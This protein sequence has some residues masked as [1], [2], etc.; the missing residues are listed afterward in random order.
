MNVVLIFTF[1]SNTSDRMRRQTLAA[2]QRIDPGDNLLT[3]RLVLCS[4]ATDRHGTTSAYVKNKKITLLTTISKA[5]IQIT[6]E[7]FLF[8][9]LLDI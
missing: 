3:V 5:K 9:F 1:H 2:K 7:T 4:L 6:E 8:L